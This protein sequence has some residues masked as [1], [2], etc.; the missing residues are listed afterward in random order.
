MFGFSMMIMAMTGLT[1][2]K[3]SSRTL[4]MISMITGCMLLHLAWMENC[5]LI[6]AMP[7]SGLEIRKVRLY[8][9]RMVMSLITKNTKRAWY[10]A[11]TRMARQW[12]VWGIISVIPM[13]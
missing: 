2:R 3:F 6:L 10:S 12:N 13:K 1:A 5:I 11:A 7:E 9:T 8:V 4:V